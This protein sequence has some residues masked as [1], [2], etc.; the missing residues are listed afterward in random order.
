MFA[1]RISWHK[2]LYPGYLASFTATMQ[3][4]D[5]KNSHMMFYLIFCVGKTVQMWN[6]GGGRAKGTTV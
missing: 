2:L 5:W 3:I 6:E 1:F 4:C